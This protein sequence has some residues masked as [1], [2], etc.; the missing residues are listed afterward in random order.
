MRAD[1]EHAQAVAA[2]VARGRFHGAVG[3]FADVGPAHG[4]DGV[5]AL[6]EVPDLAQFGVAI[7][8]H[9]YILAR[10]C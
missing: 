1:F 7:G 9:G 3:S 10:V 6:D 2:D 5:G 8:E 4:F